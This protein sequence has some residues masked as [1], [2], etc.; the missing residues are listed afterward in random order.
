VLIVALV[1][2]LVLLGAGAAT[3]YVLTRDTSPQTQ[4]STLPSA[5]ASLPEGGP[6]SPVPGSPGATG[7][8]ARF[9][10]AGQCVVNDGT[11]TKPQM[12]IVPCTSGAYEVLERF[13]GTIDFEKKCPSVPGYQYHFYYDSSLDVLDFVLCMRKR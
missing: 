2:V 3:A 13:D 10:T 9:V 11:N 7:S 12:R 4:P 8:D 6:I 1:I 5:A